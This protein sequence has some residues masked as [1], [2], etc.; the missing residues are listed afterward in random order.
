MSLLNATGPLEADRGQYAAGDDITRRSYAIIRS[1]LAQMPEGGGLARDFEPLAVRI[2]HTTGDVA[3][4]TTFDYSVGAVQ[5]GVEAIRAGR[6]IIADVGMVK[7]GVRVRHLPEPR[8]PV[9]CLLDEPETA[10]LAADERITRSAAAIRRCAPYLD[11]AVVAI[12]NAPTAL[13]ELLAMAGRGLVQ[14]ALIIGVP[15]GFVGALESKLELYG[16]GLPFITNRSERGG[17]PIAAAIVNGLIALASG[18]GD[19]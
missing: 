9:L 7:Q 5:A 13:F 16:S 19:L 4:C 12:G 8:S 1:R 2:A 11:G 6:P 3:F 18:L 10:A 17:S 15:V 14:P